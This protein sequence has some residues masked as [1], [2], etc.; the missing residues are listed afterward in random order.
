MTQVAHIFLNGEM[1]AGVP[2]PPPAGLVIAADG[3]ARWALSLGWPIHYLIGDFDSL[4]PELYL[5]IKEQKTKILTYPAEKNEIDFEL[6]LDL[7][8]KLNCLSVRIYA[9]LGGRWDMSLANLL[10]S[11]A[12]KYQKMKIVFIDNDWEIYPLTGPQKLTLTGLPGDTFSLMPFS[13]Q[14]QL[15]V[16]GAKYPLHNEYL[17]FPLSRGLSNELVENSALIEIK[18]GQ[19]LVFHQKG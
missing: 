8:L 19:L 6:A 13:A 15:N 5:Q 18:T 10:L 11:F 16:S 3:G 2:L 12:S 1:P 9:S 4:A 17:T 7:A 14:C